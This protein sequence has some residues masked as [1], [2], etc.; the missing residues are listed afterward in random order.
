MMKYNIKGKF[1]GILPKGPYPPC[2]H[3]ADR[4]FWQDTRELYYEGLCQMQ[5]QFEIRN[6]EVR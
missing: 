3:M 5:H 1:G 4:A 6:S 2:L